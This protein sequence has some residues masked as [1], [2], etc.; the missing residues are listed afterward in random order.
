MKVLR[1]DSLFFRVLCIDDDILYRTRLQQSLEA[2]GFEVVTARHG[3]DGLMQYKALDGQFDAIITCV[4]GA[5][6]NGVDLVRTFRELGYG[7]QV[8]VVAENLRKNEF[9]RFESVG[10]SGFFQKSFDGSLLAAMLLKE[11]RGQD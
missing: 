10:V 7:G 8:V 2:C 5:P 11:R 6:G 4:D 9:L 3:I 1:C